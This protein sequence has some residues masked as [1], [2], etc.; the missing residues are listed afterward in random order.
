VIFFQW[1]RVQFGQ[2]ISIGLGREAVL[3]LRRV[4]TRLAQSGH[5]E[6][7]AICPLSGVKRTHLRDDGCVSFC[8]PEL[9][10][11]ALRSSCGSLLFEIDLNYWPMEADDETRHGK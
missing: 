11:A 8:A 9:P 10:C 2:L 7:S 6:M 4:K 5:A 3:L 1:H